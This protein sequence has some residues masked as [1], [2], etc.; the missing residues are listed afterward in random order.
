ME[1]HTLILFTPL[2]DILDAINIKDIFNIIK[3]SPLEIG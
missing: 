2:I 1:S 3:E